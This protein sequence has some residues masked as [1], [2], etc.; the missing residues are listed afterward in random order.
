MFNKT[1]FCSADNKPKV[2]VGLTSASFAPPNPPP[3]PL[4]NPPPNPPPSPLL[5]PLTS[6]PPNP[7]VPKAPAPVPNKLVAL[8]EPPKLGVKVLMPNPTGF[9]AVAPKLNPV[10]P[11][12]VEVLVPA[13]TRL[14]PPNPV[15]VAVVLVVVDGAPF[16]I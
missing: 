6:P 14:N 11:P 4:L 5:N 3:S 7:V 9:A 1:L 2:N 10:V 12:A 15:E 13:P 8:E 16:M